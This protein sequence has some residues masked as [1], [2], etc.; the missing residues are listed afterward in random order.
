MIAI[1]QFSVF[2]HS[3]VP[4]F[5]YSAAQNSRLLSG[6]AAAARRAQCEEIDFDASIIPGFV[7]W[8]WDLVIALLTSAALISD[9]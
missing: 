4:T 1:F 7:I 6:D 3:N 9:L 8:H 5:H 2:H